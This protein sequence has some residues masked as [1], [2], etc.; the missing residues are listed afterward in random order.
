MSTEE[1]ICASR[2]VQVP[3]LSSGNSSP[4]KKACGLNKAFRSA[5]YKCTFSFRVSAMSSRTLSSRMF[6][7]K[8]CAMGDLL[9]MKSFVAAKMACGVHLEGL[10]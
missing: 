3:L 4:R 1:M 9:L 6:V 5:L 7:R 8:D 2:N 10:V